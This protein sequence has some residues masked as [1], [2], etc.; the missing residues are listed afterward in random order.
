MTQAYPLQWPAQRDRPR[1]R[2][3]ANFNTKTSKG[4][5]RLTVPEAVDRLQREI[6]L[7]GA[8]Q[9]VLSTNLLLRLD[10][11][12][13]SGQPE[14]D[15]PGA[16][17][18]IHLDGKDHCL[19]CDRYDRVADNIAAIA[20]HI[21]A[22]RAI[23]RYG[24]AN[25]SEMFAGFVALPAPGAKR[26]WRDVFDLNADERSRVSRAIIE[27]R[28]RKLAA[29]RHPDRASGSHEAMAELNRARDE[30]LKEIGP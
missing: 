2:L 8:A 29:E 3:T 10:G 4:Q 5:R 1:T 28:Y 22:T 15:D 24:V 20:K 16:A 19:P 23:E 6:D 7:L 26:D 21:E 12:P 11:W 30:A 9:Y 25:L 18:Y 13:R 27:G 14:P 17:L